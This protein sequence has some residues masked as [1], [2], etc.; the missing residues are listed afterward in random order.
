MTADYVECPEVS[1]K[2]IH[3]LRIYKDS[4]DGTEL[5][6]DM[7]DGTTFSFNLL[8]KPLLEASVIRAGVGE[9]EVLRKYDL[10]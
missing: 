4:G 8:V 6:I 9:P 1:G 5:Q 7:T 3:S 2:T 10:E